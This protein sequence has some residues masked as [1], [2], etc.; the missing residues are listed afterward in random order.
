IRKFMNWEKGEEKFINLYVSSET[1]PFAASITKNGFEFSRTGNLFVFPLTLPVIEYKGTLELLSQTESKM[2]KLLI[3]RIN[4]SKP[5]INIDIGDIIRIVDQESLPQIEGKILRANFQ[6]KYP[7]KLTPEIPVP[8]ENKVYVGDL[9]YFDEFDFYYPRGLINCLNQNC[10]S[11]IDSL[12]LIEEDFE[13]GEKLKL[14]IPSNGKKDC[15]NL[16][17]NRELLSKCINNERFK[18]AI[19]NNQIEIITLEENPIDFLATR[20]EMLD[21]VRKGL[22]SKGIL[23]KWPLYVIRVQ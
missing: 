11:D 16:S 7:I 6:L 15:I 3:S 14:F 22:I 17:R 18:A 2:G 13:D 1:G 8:P 4:N 19:L 23:K 9:F 20:K 12:L 21:K 5:F 10:N